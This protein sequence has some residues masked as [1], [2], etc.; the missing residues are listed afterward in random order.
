MRG[1]DSNT[2]GREAIVE[3]LA[4]FPRVSLAM[5]PTPLVEARRLSEAL[6]GPRIL[7]KREDLAGLGLGGSKYRILEFTI[8]NA[9]S[10]GADVLIAGGVAQS[11]HPQQI[12]SAAAHLGVPVVIILGG[13]EG[14]VGWTGNMLLEGLSGAEI[15]VLPLAGFDEVRGAQEAMSERLRAEGRNPAIVTL[16]REVHLRSVFAYSSY[17][18]ELA[19]QLE[20]QGIE[21]RALYI[22]SGG[23]TYAGVL[24]GTLALGS[25]FEVI[26]ITPRGSA[27]ECS[28]HVAGLVEEAARMMGIAVPLKPESIRI[29]DA[30]QGAGHGVTTAGAVEAIKLMA[31]TEGLFLDPVYSGKAMAGLIDHVRRGRFDPGDT[32]VFAHTGGIPALFAYADQLMLGR[33]PVYDAGNGRAGGIEDSSSWG[34]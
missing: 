15:H 31:S 26:G 10:Q 33:V 20:E 9:L 23:P 21:A 14:R 16:T 32:V 11:N 1:R 5:L 29:T 30:Y 17:A 6:G 28:E 2:A 13:G 4:R 22:G 7:V 24:L 34:M 25:P 8:G 12:A 19:R 18:V 3:A 27:T